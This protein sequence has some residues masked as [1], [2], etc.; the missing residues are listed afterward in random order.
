MLDAGF[1]IVRYALLKT[2]KILYAAGS[3]TFIC[4][5]IY[6]KD[7]NQH[8][9]LVLYFELD[10]FGFFCSWNQKII[11][12]LIH[13]LLNMQLLGV[14]CTSSI[15]CEVEYHK[16]SCRWVC[17][18][19]IL[20]LPTVFKVHM[21]GCNMFALYFLNLSICWIV[22]LSALW[23]VITHKWY[24]LLKRLYAASF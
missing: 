2:L 16:C 1:G 4:V 24:N 10:M 5:W 8:T 22:C 21:S 15:S 3:S 17:R 11:W 6:L 20:L 14:N 7:L 19:Y 9:C 12:C 23:L 13:Q 18:C